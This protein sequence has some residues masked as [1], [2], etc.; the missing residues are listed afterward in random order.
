M[1][2]SLWL[3]KVCIWAM[4]F[5]VNLQAQIRIGGRTSRW[6]WRSLSLR[7]NL[8]SIWVLKWRVQPGPSC[9]WPQHLPLCHGGGDKAAEVCEGRYL[10]QDLSYTIDVASTCWGP[11]PHLFGLDALILRPTLAACSTSAA[12]FCLV[13]VILWLSKTI[14]SAKS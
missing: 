12:N 10:F 13:W 5:F 6:N 9:T 4:I 14:S 1:Y 2:R 3:V 7:W 11:N 8:I